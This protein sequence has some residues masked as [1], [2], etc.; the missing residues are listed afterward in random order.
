MTVKVP[1]WSA[2]EEFE[3][4]E[5]GNSGFRKGSWGFLCELVN[6]RVRV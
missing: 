3:A 4:F 5:C 2:G 1:N 6:E